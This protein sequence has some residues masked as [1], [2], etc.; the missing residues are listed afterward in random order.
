[1]TKIRELD[2]FVNWRLEVGICLG[3]E[4]WDLEFGPIFESMR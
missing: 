2:S 3:F 1:M 4:N